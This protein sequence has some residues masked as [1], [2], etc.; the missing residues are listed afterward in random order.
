MLHY[1]N[2]SFALPNGW[3]VTKTGFDQHGNE[4]ILSLGNYIT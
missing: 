1:K 4:G 3:N 2:V